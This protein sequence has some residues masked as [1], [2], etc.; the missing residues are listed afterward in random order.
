VSLPRPSTILALTLSTLR[1]TAGNGKSVLWQ[2]LIS[3]YIYFDNN[4]MITPAV[5]L[6]SDIYKRHRKE[7]FSITTSTSVMNQR[8]HSKD[9]SDRSWHSYFTRFL[10]SRFPS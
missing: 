1:F 9:L 2:V 10:R 7:L 4:Q 5:L 3:S 8:A 6:R